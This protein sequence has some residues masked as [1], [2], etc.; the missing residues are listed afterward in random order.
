MRLCGIMKGG[1]WA[2][3][4]LGSSQSLH[5]PTCND[6]EAFCLTHKM[7]NR[8]LLLLGFV[9]VSEILYAKNSNT[10]MSDNLIFKVYK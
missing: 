7:G 9:R 3:A 10:R 6:K 8:R 4:Y 2:Q 1:L 5:S